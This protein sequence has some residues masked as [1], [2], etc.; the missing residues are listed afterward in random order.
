MRSI[1]YGLRLAPN[2]FVG[3]TKN[4]PAVNVDL[5][6][7]EIRLQFGPCPRWGGNPL[8]GKLQLPPCEP[9]R[10]A[11]AADMI[12]QSHQSQVLKINGEH[13]L[14]LQRRDERRLVPGCLGVN[15]ALMKP[16]VESVPC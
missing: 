11:L 8:L 4:T 7:G 14:C 12:G 6:R 13:E 15:E 10:T 3:P 9:D 1:L 5:G 2:P 16:R